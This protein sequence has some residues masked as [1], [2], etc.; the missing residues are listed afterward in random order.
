MANF[1]GTEQTDG[2]ND[3]ELTT[4]NI[5]AVD[6]LLIQAGS[7]LNDSNTPQPVNVKELLTAAVGQASNIDTFNV[8]DY[9]I[10]NDELPD[11][12][13]DSNFVT[14]QHTLM[15]VEN[16]L[17][18][19]GMNPYLFLGGDSAGTNGSPAS[20][21]QY[22]GNPITFDG[23]D[24]DNGKFENDVYVTDELYLHYDDEG[25]GGQARYILLSAAMAAM[26]GL[27]TA[28]LTI[29]PV[30]RSLHKFG[31]T[32]EFDVDAGINVTV[33]DYNPDI[34]LE[35]DALTLHTDCQIFISDNINDPITSSCTI[36]NF[37]L[38]ANDNLD[39]TFTTVTKSGANVTGNCAQYGT[40]LQSDGG[41]GNMTSNNLFKG[42]FGELLAESPIVSA[43]RNSN[44]EMVAD[45]LFEL[46]VER[47]GKLTL[48]TN[49]WLPGQGNSAPSN[50]VTYSSQYDSNNPWL[51]QY[52]RLEHAQLMNEL[53]AAFV[54]VWSNTTN[55]DWYVT[56]FNIKESGPLFNT[57]NNQTPDTFRVPVDVTFNYEI[58]N[59]NYDTDT[60]VTN[61]NT[62]NDTDLT[63]S[64]D[65]M[66]F[67][68]SNLVDTNNDGLGKI[69]KTYRLEYVFNVTNIP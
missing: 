17:H 52:F 68:I 26:Q 44:N 43:F 10:E 36:A 53:S 27:L 28:V 54:N 51:D 24:P 34:I 16:Q 57:G 58:V 15:Y 35:G 59:A 22:G 21:I 66:A 38:G 56:A 61:S 2:F 9:L 32:L 23:H 55:I 8:G 63:A 25:V 40:W 11:I 7:D 60:L 1:D 67:E 12:L 19:S 33:E 30:K 20:E 42:L 4:F 48:N 3:V 64:L 39:A 50:P 49:I 65:P 13:N 14:G 46:V 45:D 62:P 69:Q 6:E 41:S 31:Y 5:L 47:P 18:V 29:N 37:E